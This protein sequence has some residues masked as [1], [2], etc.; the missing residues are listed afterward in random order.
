MHAEKNANAM[1]CTVVIIKA[2]LPK[3][4]A[5]EAIQIAARDAFGE[6]HAGERNMAFKHEGEALTHFIRWRANR[7]STGDV[8]GAVLILAAA[9]D[10]EQRAAFEIFNCGCRDTKMH[11]CAVRAS[12]RNGLKAQVFKIAILNAKAFQFLRSLDFIMLAVLGSGVEPMQKAR[13]RCAVSNMGGFC[14]RNLGG[15]FTGLW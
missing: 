6:A 14:T 12:A 11:N 9:I 1:A 5:G 3:G 15:I 2:A 13:N 10:E 7:N 4:H 8:G